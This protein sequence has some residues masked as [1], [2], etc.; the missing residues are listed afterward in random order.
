MT[1]H[2]AA[3]P[4]GALEVLR[5]P[6]CGDAFAFDERRVVCERRHSFDLGRQGYVTLRRGSRPTVNADTASMVAA[7]SLVLGSGLY[8]RLRECVG[9][10]VAAGLGAGAGGAEGVGAG[11]PAEPPVL[12]DLAGGTG[13]Y[14][15]GLVDRVPGSLGFCLDLSTPAVKRAASCHPRVVAVGADVMDP[16]PLAPRSVAVVTSMFG[17]R[18]VAEIERVLAPGGIVVVVTPTEQHLSELIEPLAMVRVDPR[19]P[20]RLARALAAFTERDRRSVRYEA[21]VTAEQMRALVAMGPSAHHAT[22]PEIA[23]R[24]ARLGATCGAEGRVT[25]TVAVEIHVFERA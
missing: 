24:V 25:A 6:L 4:P 1:A 8:G 10:A 5:C 18:P 19:K 22:E 7:R 11:A 21:T 23:E 13:Y 14:L 15:A 16:L 2:P 20:E 9:D 12:I 17:P 3:W